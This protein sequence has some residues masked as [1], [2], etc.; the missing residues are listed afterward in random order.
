MLGLFYGSFHIKWS[1]GHAD[2]ISDLAHS[3][4]FDLF[5][6]KYS[7]IHVCG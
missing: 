4:T 6:Q 3:V 7:T 1:S 2:T 5:P